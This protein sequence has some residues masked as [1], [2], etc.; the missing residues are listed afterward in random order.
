M[1]IKFQRRQR[2]RRYEE[3]EEKEEEENTADQI[4][5][6]NDEAMMISNT[7]SKRNEE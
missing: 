3:E 1:L 6:Q 2:K 5:I 4:K 7:D